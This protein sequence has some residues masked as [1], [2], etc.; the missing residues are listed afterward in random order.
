MR[1]VFVTESLEL[2]Q[3]RQKV[4]LISDQGSIQQLASIGLNPSLHDGVHPQHTYT[5]LDG[6]YL[7]TG[8]NSQDLWIMSS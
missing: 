5:A 2:A 6:A 1:P 3:R 8:S 4:A 7:G